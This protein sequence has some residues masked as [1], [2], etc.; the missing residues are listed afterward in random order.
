MLNKN[1]VLE[2]IAPL[3]ADFEGFS[4]K[5]YKCPA[6]FDTI[7]YGRNIEA[8]PLNS[9]EKAQLK[10]GEV[11]KKVALEWLKEELGK[12]YDRLEKLSWFRELDNNRAAAITDMVYNLGYS[13]F[14][15]FKNSIAMIAN[16]EW[17]KASENLKKS[18]WYKQVKRRGVKIVDIIL[19]GEI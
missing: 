17:H 1:E 3:T 19:T 15:G 18:K 7:G 6:G 11:S 13:G 14:M 10:N 8:N 12:C 9:A 5:V 16:K 4:A 2:T